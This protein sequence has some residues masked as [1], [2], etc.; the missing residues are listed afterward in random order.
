MIFRFFSLR[1][2]KPPIEQTI[3]FINFIKKWSH[4]VF[5]FLVT[6]VLY[7]SVLNYYTPRSFNLKIELNCE[8]QQCQ[9]KIDDSVIQKI[10]SDL[11]NQIE[12]ANRFD[13]LAKPFS[14][15]IRVEP[16]LTNNSTFT[17][18]VLNPDQEVHRKSKYKCQLSNSYSFA[19]GQKIIF[20]NHK[21]SLI[22]TPV[23][24]KSVSNTLL[25]CFRGF[26]S[27]SEPE[28][29][30]WANKNSVIQ[31]KDININFLVEFFPDKL[32]KFLILLQSLGILL[33]LLPLVREGIRFIKRGWTYWIN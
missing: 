5:L 8:Q 21:S 24:V 33:G 4:I 17:I 19:Y 7:Y 9:S 28:K 29:G 2:I 10:N 1:K 14:G 32:S 12:E 22:D 18:T 13:A 3:V 31:F 11:Q 23:V 16:Q 25:K 6:I 15:F 30:I 27:Q 20:F 26:E